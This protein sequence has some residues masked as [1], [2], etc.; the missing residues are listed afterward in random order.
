MAS[1]LLSTGLLQANTG[2]FGLFAQQAHIL[3]TT[4]TNGIGIFLVLHKEWQMFGD[5]RSGGV[6]PVIRMIV[7]DDNGIHIDKLIDRQRQLDQRIAQLA[8]GGALKAGEGTFC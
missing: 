3:K 5:Q 4:G 6:I 7:G 8:I 1:A 2:K